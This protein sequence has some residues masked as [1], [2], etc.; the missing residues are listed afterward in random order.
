MPIRL[1]DYTE[2]HKPALAARLDAEG[3]TKRE[4]AVGLFWQTLLSDPYKQN[5]VIVVATEDAGE[6]AG[7]GRAVHGIGI[8]MRRPYGRDS[9][10]PVFYWV[11]TEKRRQG[12]GAMLKQAIGK[13]LAAAGV[14]TQ[15][16][17]LFN[18]QEDAIPFLTATGFQ[19]ICCDLIIGWNGGEYTYKPV[20]GVS[21][22]IYRGG[23][24]VL[25][26]KIAA[27]QNK[28][29]VRET[30]VPHLTGDSIEHILV[31]EKHWM[32]V[33]TEDATGEVVGVTECSDTNIF[34]SI[35][36]ARRYWA[37]GLAEWIG[38]LSLDIYVAAG[39][40]DPWTIVRPVNRAS[41]AYLARMN[42]HEK[43]TIT[44]FG[45]PTQDDA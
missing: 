27:F 45:A 23:D 8:G 20:E 30:M 32:M 4:G 5:S 13:R 33:A 25:N 7:E 1:E 29:F 9:G 43:G 39:I 24:P 38:G 42:W 15:Y 31:N 16:G 34:P 41:L 36:V 14:P 11:A 17:S 3:L 12:I 21:C 18:G 26:E 10:R 35:S 28:A 2:A 6:G 44:S 40:T 37:S 19:Q 22:A